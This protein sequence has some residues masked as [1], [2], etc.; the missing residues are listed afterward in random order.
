MVG[1]EYKSGMNPF[2]VRRSVRNRVVSDAIFKHTDPRWWLQNGF[3]GEYAE[4]AEK[5]S[6]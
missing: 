1:V 5:P 4:V 2:P 3:V 6:G